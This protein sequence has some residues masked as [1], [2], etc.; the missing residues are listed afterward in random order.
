MSRQFAPVQADEMLIEGSF[1]DG[2]ASISIKGSADMRSKDVL[3]AAL[4][5]IHDMVIT[6]ALTKV[7]VDF[8]ELRFMSSSC[9]KAFVTWLAEAQDLE[10]SQR[11]SVQFLSNEAIE[12]QGR[13]LDALRCFA[14][15]LNAT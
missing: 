10:P 8:R 13:S 7:I 5:R 3:L 15:D 1:D 9:F 6:E 4:L 11:Y 2:G 14:G 12:W